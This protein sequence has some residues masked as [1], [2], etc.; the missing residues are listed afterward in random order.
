MPLAS[1]GMALT[2][3]HS[4]TGTHTHSEFFKNS[5]YFYCSCSSIFEF[6][7]S[8]K[9]TFKKRQEKKCHQLRTLETQNNVVHSLKKNGKHF[10]HFYL[11]YELCGNI[12]KLNE[13]SYSNHLYRI[14]S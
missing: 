6:F 12:F 9:Q 5:I 4:H 1:R 13:F 7:V 10:F 2:C 11:I 14:S 3:M 8:M